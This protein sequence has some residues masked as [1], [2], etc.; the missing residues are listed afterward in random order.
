[1]R[2]EIGHVPCRS[3]SPHGVFGCFHSAAPEQSGSIEATTAVINVRLRALMTT[4]D[5]RRNRLSRIRLPYIHALSRL[6]YADIIVKTSVPRCH[7]NPKRRSPGM[8][9]G[10][11][12]LALVVAIAGSTAVRAA[13]APARLGGKP[14]LN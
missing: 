3:G 13:D 8:K 2:C 11:F 10:R 4:P 12:L 9:T 6:A 1:M 7:E 5:S 14:N